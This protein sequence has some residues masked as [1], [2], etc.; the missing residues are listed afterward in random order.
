MNKQEYLAAVELVN[1]YNHEYYVMDNPTV[2]DAEYDRLMNSILEFE[3]KNPSD[4]LPDSPTQKVGG[5]VL[6]EFTSVEHLKPMLSL[7]NVFEEEGMTKFYND[8]SEEHP[9]IEYVGEYKMDGIALSIIYENGILVRGATRGDGV[10]GEDIT[11]N[12]KTIRNVPLK[13]K[14]DNPPAL[15][16][17]RGE[18]VFPKKDFDKLNEK[19]RKEGKKTYVNPRNAAAGACRNLDSSITRERALKFFCYGFGESSDLDFGE[20]HYDTMKKLQ[21]MGITICDKL[22]KSKNLSDLVQFYNE[23]MNGRDSLPYDIDGVV[24]KVNNYEQQNEIGFISKS[25]KWAKAYKFPAQ[26]EMTILKAI[27]IQVGRT[28]A[29]TPVARLEPVF[30]GGVTVSNATLHNFPEIKRLDARVGDTVII[31]R[32]GDVIPQVVSVVMSKRPSSAISYA[33]PTKCPCC[34]SKV[35]RID[36]Q[37]VLKCQGGMLCEPQKVGA[38]QHFAKRDAM[39]IDKLGDASIEKFVQLGFLNS[40]VDIFKLSNHKDS[41]MKL[42]GFGEK[43]INSMIESIENSKETTLDRFI[44]SLG[45]TEVGRSLSKN[46]AKSLKSFDKFLMASYDELIA[47]ED[48]GEISARHIIQFQQDFKN[49]DE[50]RELSNVGIH[51]PDIESSVVGDKLTGM[52]FVITG[53]FSENREYFKD[54]VE[55]NGGKTSGSVSKKTTYLLAGEKAGSKLSKAESLGVT[56]ISDT[57]FYQMIK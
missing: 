26:E 16:E 33:E 23:T 42:E 49:N 31:R 54:L 43:S 18:V 57:D 44:Y 4:M 38:I 40:P 30:V 51:W 32:A 28:G 45:I 6:D 34:G 50:L 7:D 48:L 25:P 12:V 20:S 39:D 8:I 55:A 11:E 1:Q 5:T 35:A 41:L 47:I 37:V 14:T 2:P 22:V 21:N 36:E 9:E 17:I 56:V 52:V 29:L 27:D 46:I 53:S 15:L 13:L 24:F 3:F 19:L 10:K